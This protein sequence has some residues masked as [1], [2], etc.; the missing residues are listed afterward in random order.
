ML[1]RKSKVPFARAREFDRRAL[2]RASIA[3]AVASGMLLGAS[4]SDA[5][6][7]RIEMQPA[8]IAFGGYA[9]PGVG[10]YEVI[11]GVAY[12]E[13][14]PGNPLNSVITDIELA[15]RNA[16]GNVEYSHNFYILKPVD[17]SKGNHQ[18]MYEPPNRGNKTF[19]T[20]NRTPSGT[21]PGTTITDPDTLANSFLWPRGYTM[22]FSG[23][24]N[25]LGDLSNPNNY[26]ASAHYP[27]L[28]N[29]DDSAITG[30]AYEY[31]VT[32][33]A[34][35]ALSYPAATGDKSAAKLTHRV[36]LDDT[37]QTVPESGWDYTNAAHTAIRLT[38]GNF[39][40]NDIYEFSYTAKDPTPNGM[41]FAAVRD[42]VSFIRY[43][44]TDDFG[45]ANPLAGDVTR[46]YSETL[47]QPGRLLND[48][49]TLGFNQ[50]ESG[51]KVIDGMMQWIAAA[52]GLNMNYRWSQTKRTN[53]NRQELLFL[54]GTF[55]FANVETTDPFTGK[56]D[57]RYARCEKTNTCPLAVEIY[58]AN[59]YWV[60]AASLLHTDPAG[61]RD[62]PDSPY[63]RNYFIS[64][65][66]HTP[67][68][69]SSRGS[70]QQ[71][72]NPLNSAPIQRA[73]FLALDDWQ[74]GIAPPQS[75]VPKL[76]DN[77]LV[78]PL[79]QTAVGFPNIP[80]VTYT[81]LKTT[82]YLFDY[83]PNF[84][85]TGVPTIN[86]PHVT[87]PYQDNPANGPFYGSLVPKTDSD[88]ND[89]AGVRLPDVTVPLATYTG[90]GLRAGVWANDGCESSGQYIPFRRTKAERVAAGDP[91]PSIEERYKS[92]GQYRSAVVNA[93]DALVKERLL[94]CEDAGD[95]V[96][97]L[98]DAGIAAGVPGP[99]GHEPMYPN[100]PHCN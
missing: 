60:K 14:D 95:Q 80:G 36:H 71:L 41:G 18:V 1:A 62:L 38:T 70:C 78:P 10:Q 25:G 77:T 74:N 89:I 100:V 96:Q 4:V 88:G 32:G 75:R 94:L 84:Y 9:F 66:Q 67:G 63:A 21:D 16:N 40:S 76:S 79:P 17:L 39:V 34:T 27:V 93:V 37:P 45:H 35:Y 68:N 43:A 26:T 3:S 7:T 5:R 98:I 15:P 51:R 54:E 22:V 83:G 97:R 53:R 19:G 6:T 48:F 90:W 24:E 99:N 85:E 30:P 29:P 57:S 64:S 23:W 73:L 33:G 28:K 52:D 2:L 91:R 13:I 58:S 92:F 86:P 59:E 56:T 42:F 55:P 49:T 20:L 61:T 69:A 8:R 47:S 65:H 46:L 81:G 87:A 12:G 50:D 11:S 31:I 72:Q 82:R 44:A